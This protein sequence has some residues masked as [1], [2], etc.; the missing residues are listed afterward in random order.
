MKDNTVIK[1]RIGRQIRA[2]RLRAEYSSYETFAND[3][4]L[5]RKTY[6]RLEAGHNFTID[7]LLRV[8][9]IHKMTIEDFFCE[10]KEKHFKDI[11]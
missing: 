11:P 6:W 5:P 1:K 3:H 8:L 2:L 9:N 10:L 4:E 7:T